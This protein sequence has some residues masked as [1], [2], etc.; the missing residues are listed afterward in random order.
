MNGECVSYDMKKFYTYE[1]F[2][3]FPDDIQLKYINGLI[4]R[5]NVTVSAIAEEV[6]H[7]TP[8]GFFKH[9]RKK[10][11]TQY[12]NKAPNGKSSI[13]VEGRARL[14]IAI[15]DANKPKEEVV[16]EPVIEEPI[17]E[18]KPAI[19]V[20]TPEPVVEE[21]TEPKVFANFRSMRI[22]MNDWD[23]DILDFLRTRFAGGDYHIAIT[24]DKDS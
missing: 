7:I 14:M 11:L 23:S 20:V 12:I 15:E 21:P 5:Y 17:P 19:E 16:S 18:S 3:T 2:K 13:A 10:D 22:E 4:N 24:V 8:T 1:E 9:L 6:F